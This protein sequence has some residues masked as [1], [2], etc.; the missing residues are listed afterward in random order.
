MTLIDKLFNQLKKAKPDS[1]VTIGYMG[2][3]SSSWIEIRPNKIDFNEPNIVVEVLSFNGKGT[4]LT[5][6]AAYYEH[7]TI[8]FDS[9]RVSPKNKP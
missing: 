9:E 2:D 7:I 5:D 4:K 6:V 1:N 3:N 8:Q